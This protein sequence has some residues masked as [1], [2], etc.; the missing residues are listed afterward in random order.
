[1]F[2]T[3]CLVSLLLSTLHSEAIL[4]TVLPTS[5]LLSLYTRFD[6]YLILPFRQ[7][8]RDPKKFMNREHN[9][10]LGWL[11]PDTASI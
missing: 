11:I 5:V 6:R 7:V 10:D 1:M 8:L 9:S 4:L 3:T 2:F